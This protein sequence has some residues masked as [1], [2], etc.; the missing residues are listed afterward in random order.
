LN[1]YNHK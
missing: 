1:K